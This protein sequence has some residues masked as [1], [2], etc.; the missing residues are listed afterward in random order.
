[1]ATLRAAWEA[2][3]GDLRTLLAGRSESSTVRSLLP[4]ATEEMTWRG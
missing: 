4:R 1:M 3:A 2:A